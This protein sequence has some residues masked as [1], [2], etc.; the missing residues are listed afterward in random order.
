MATVSETLSERGKRYGDFTDRAELCQAIKTEMMTT[1]G[2]AN[3]HAVQAQALEVIADKIARILTGDPD[4]EDN[5]HDIQ[6]YAALVE[7]RL[8]S[9]VAGRKEAAKQAKPRETPQ[10]K[11]GCY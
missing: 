2:Y 10:F 1:P 9:I 8:P 5:W 6:G 11:P 7:V 4:Y 3:L